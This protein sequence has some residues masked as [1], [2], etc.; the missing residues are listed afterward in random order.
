L[1]I[2]SWAER[3]RWAWPADLNRFICRSRVVGS[4]GANSPPGCSGPC[5]SGARP[6]A[7]PPLRGAVAGQLVRDHDTR[8]AGPAASAACGAGAWRPACPAGSGP[9]RR[10]RPHPGRPPA[11]AS[12]SCPDHQAHFVEVPLVAR[13]GQPAPD[14]VG[15]AWPNLRAHCRTVSWLTSM[16]RAASISSTMRRLSGKAEVEPDGVADDLARKAV[17]GVGGLG[18]GCHAGHLPVPAFPAKPRPKLTVP[19]L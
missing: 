9:E 18:C 16:P 11:R 7:S 3:K 15:E 14:L 4:A 8:A 19:C 13:T 17:A 1:L 10:A 6:R 2:W 5:A 12:A